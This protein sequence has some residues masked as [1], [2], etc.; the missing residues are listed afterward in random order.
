[1]AAVTAHFGTVALNATTEVTVTLD[2]TYAYQVRHTGI[3][4]TGT[5][6]AASQIWAFL[7]YA[8]GLAAVTPA[9]EDDKYV[10]MTSQSVEIGPG[11]ST[12]YIDSIAT[13]DGILTFARKGGSRRDW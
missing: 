9:E 13:A 12:L 5:A 6:D 10:L 4:A 3:D 8:S 7:S 11:I 1:M 2:P